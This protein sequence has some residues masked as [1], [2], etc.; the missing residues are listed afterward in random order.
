MPALPYRQNP[1]QLLEYTNNTSNANALDKHL[2]NNEEDIRQSDRDKQRSAT[3]SDFTPQNKLLN[4]L[5]S[6]FKEIT[7]SES[8]FSAS[9]PILNTRYKHS[10]TQN[11]NRFHLFNDQH[12][13]ALAHYFAKSETT[14]RN[15]DKFLSN[16]LM[17]P[18]TKKLSYRNADE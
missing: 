4:K 1:E 18:I 15:I 6:T 16:L 3:L 8:K 13:Y 2:D 11:K 7:F 10:G 17:K 12:D 5:S 9:T 14:K